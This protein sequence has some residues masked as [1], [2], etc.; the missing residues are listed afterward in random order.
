MREHR[1]GVHTS[2]YGYNRD[3][4]QHQTERTKYGY[5]MDRKCWVNMRKLDIHRSCIYNLDS[6]YL[7]IKVI[8]TPQDKMCKA[9]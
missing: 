6:I 3:K 8:D 4:E 9:V 1:L 5:N 2:I 7:P